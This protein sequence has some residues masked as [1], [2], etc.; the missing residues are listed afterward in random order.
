MKDRNACEQ[1]ELPH[2]HAPVGHG[3]CRLG[4]RQGDDPGGA[5]HGGDKAVELAARRGDLHV[6]EVALHGLLDQESRTGLERGFLGVEVL[7]GAFVDD[8]DVACGIDGQGVEIGVDAFA[9]R[10]L[11]KPGEVRRLVQRIER[12]DQPWGRP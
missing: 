10:L 3:H 5:R 11:H 6:V 4:N 1:G 7:E 12:A 8:V 2:H 9:V